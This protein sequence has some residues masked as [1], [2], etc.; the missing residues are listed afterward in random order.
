MKLPYN[1]AD[2]F[3][4]SVEST[5][6]QAPS[7]EKS[8]LEKQAYPFL[9]GF[10]RKNNKKAHRIRL[11]AGP[12]GLTT[13]TGKVLLV[14]GLESLVQ[15]EVGAT[16]TPTGQ[17]GGFLGFDCFFRDL[18]GKQNSRPCADRSRLWRPRRHLRSARERWRGL[19]R[20][21]RRSASGTKK[22]AC[23]IC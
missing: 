20:S 17:G 15:V 16:V 11:D 3:V 6:N 22:W 13:A 7:L 9:V 8:S 2:R 14:F 10:P 21:G 19:A 18:E 1:S 5:R 4:E 12:P 23:L